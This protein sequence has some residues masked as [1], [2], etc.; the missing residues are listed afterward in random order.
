MNN[1]LTFTLAAPLPPSLSPTS[2]LL[3]A[4]QPAGRVWGGDPF[5][6]VWQ[7]GFSVVFAR[8]CDCFNQSQSAQ[9]AFVCCGCVIAGSL[10]NDNTC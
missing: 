8:Y 9:P 1:V 2:R 4:A 6:R 10:G 7:V 5:V 3:P